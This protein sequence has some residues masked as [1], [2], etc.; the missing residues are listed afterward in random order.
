[1]TKFELEFTGYMDFKT[2]EDAPK[3][4]YELMMKFNQ[5][6]L[7]LECFG[8]LKCFGDSLLKEVELK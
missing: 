4:V 5:D 8:D 1:M 2:E 6:L 3:R 7:D